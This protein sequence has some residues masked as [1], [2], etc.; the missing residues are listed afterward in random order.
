MTSNTLPKFTAH[1]TNARKGA[2]GKYSLLICVGVSPAN[3]GLETFVQ[4]K[5]EARRVC[6]EMGA[7]PWNF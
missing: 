4:D 5:R 3:G 7:T 2:P 1:L 6:A